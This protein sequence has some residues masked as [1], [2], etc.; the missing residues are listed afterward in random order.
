M[1]YLLLILFCLAPSV[2]EG[3]R[4]NYRSRS[5]NPL[6][7]GVTKQI[8]PVYVVPPRRIVIRKPAKPAVPW[9]YHH[10]PGHKVPRSTSTPGVTYNRSYHT[11]MAPKPLTIINPYFKPTKKSPL[12]IDGDYHRNKSPKTILNPYFKPSEKK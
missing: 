5:S 8:V 1:R 3:G 6:K 10:Y 7:H 9:P 12:D 2:C 11:P 4:Y